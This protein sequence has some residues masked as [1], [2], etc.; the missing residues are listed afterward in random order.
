MSNDWHPTQAIGP[1]GQ[2]AD[3]KDVANG[4]K[5]RCVCFE[6]EQP[7]IAKQG[8]KVKWHFAHHAPTSCRPSPESE[9]H[10]YAKSLLAE[11]LWCWIPEVDAN[12]A[13]MTKRISARRKFQFAEVKVEKA[14]GNVRPDLLLIAKGGKILHVE[15][16]VRHKVDAIK[17]EKLRTR[18]I[19][20]IEIDLSR[21][22]WEDRA[23]WE[24]AILETAPREWLHNVKASQAEREMVVT[25]TRQA[26]K[27]AAEIDAQFTR[28]SKVWKAIPKSYSAPSA[29]LLAEQALAR[30]R[31]FH[32]MIAH[33]QNGEGCF[34]VAP[35]FWQSRLMNHFLWDGVAGTPHAF[36][37]KDALAY[38]KDLVR[39]GL[40]RMS[41]DVAARL[42]K[43]SPEFQSPWH[44]VHNY[45]K[46]LKAHHWMFDKRV[47]GKHWLPSGSAIHR[48][49]E[50]ETAWDRERERK[51]DMAEWVDYI[52]SN[53][54]DDEH[55]EFDCRSWVDMF[56]TRYDENEAPAL[57]EA[58]HEMVVGGQGLADDL[59][60]LPLLAEYERQKQS[61]AKRR[62]EK[63][64]KRLA[65]LERSQRESRILSLRQKAEL[66]FGTE[67][68]AWLETACEHF[69]DQTPLAA[70]EASDD[71]LAKACTELRRLH[72]QRKDA[73]D[74]NAAEARQKTLLEK[75]CAELA[76]LASKRTSD[77]ARANL[78]CRSSHP[79]LGGQRP[80]DFCVDERALRICKDI[81]P[82]KL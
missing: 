58:I 57:L 29:Q 1:D 77:P 30:K 45:L 59:L 81:M 56:V 6:C 38:V 75:N 54:P 18:G 50:Q 66:V 25:A 5:C 41:I 3:V 47:V 40:N 65:E 74:R 20:S 48:R 62:I 2:R 76:E 80:F 52:L 42:E 67:A 34:R 19:S 78:W 7:V 51:A 24:L 43:E 37:T 70:A 53:I 82:S 21:L 31:G 61:Q 68:Q 27:R 73:A 12:A 36:E 28:I 9:L 63:E 49:K 44:A 72:Q 22:D 60:E 79:K 69:E 71:G 4:L 8:Q 55:R 33:T 17:L 23:E 16:Y 15:I 13:E 64:E 14:D 11:R 46:W 39:P 26:E 10:F 35:E 32:T